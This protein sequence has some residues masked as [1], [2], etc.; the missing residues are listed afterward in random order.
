MVSNACLSNGIEATR[1]S[2]Y[3]DTGPDVLEAGGP[4]NSRAFSLST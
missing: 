4:S 2:R 1:V 3:Y